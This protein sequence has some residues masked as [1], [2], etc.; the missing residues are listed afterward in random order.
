MIIKK[1]FQISIKIKKFRIQN[2]R[3]YNQNNFIPLPFNPKSKEL[4]EYQKI[5]VGKKNPDFQKIEKFLDET[6][7]K[8]EEDFKSNPEMRNMDSILDNLK[9]FYK[10]TF[11]HAIKNQIDNLAS[12]LLQKNFEFF[13]KFPKLLIKYIQVLGSNILL[14]DLRDILEFFV[15]KNIYIE[16]NIIKKNIRKYYN[17][18][19]FKKCHL[20]LTYYENN[21]IK[22]KKQEIYFF[23]YMI[24]VL[25]KKNDRRI[26]SFF[27]ICRKKNF[28][29]QSD[30]FDVY[31]NYHLRNNLNIENLFEIFIRNHKLLKEIIN[32][33]TLFKFLKLSLNFE[34]KKNTSYLHN[35]ITQNLNIKNENSLEFLNNVKNIINNKNM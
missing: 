25:N 2:I 15:S 22:D 10:L 14:Y 24:R 20:L 27:N 17:E 33:K 16:Y 26:I 29:L 21:Y 13:K 30:V 19:Q 1:L 9:I 32:K 7:L 28:L 31:L 34:N 4:E 35:F 3:K 8:Y 6:F 23:K 18:N 11:Y 5:S 12:N